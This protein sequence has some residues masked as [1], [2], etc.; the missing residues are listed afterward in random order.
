MWT[1][2]CDQWLVKLPAM[3][4]DLGFTCSCC[5]E[6]HAE[7]PMSYSTVAPDVWDQNFA[8]DP[9]SMLSSDQCVIKGQHYFIKGLIE[10][11]DR[12]SVV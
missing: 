3:A 4:N 9:D 10:I 1:I 5:G 7:P 2:A 11:P 6:Y 12:K 8:D